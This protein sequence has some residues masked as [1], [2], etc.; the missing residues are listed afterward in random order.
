M[1]RTALPKS[2]HGSWVGAICGA[3]VLCPALGWRHSGPV[4]ALKLVYSPDDRIRYLMSCALNAMPHGT[5][6]SRTLLCDHHKSV[7]RMTRD[8]V[9]GAFAT[10]ACLE[11]FRFFQST[12]QFLGRCSACRRSPL[13]DEPCIPS[14]RAWSDKSPS[15]DNTTE[16]SM[17]SSAVPC[18]TQDQKISNKL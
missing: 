16:V 11:Y 6:S 8:G 3:Q 10:N 12:R 4:G 2:V 17:V 18:G 5:F 9:A 1:S 15:K 14:V 13:A 7:V